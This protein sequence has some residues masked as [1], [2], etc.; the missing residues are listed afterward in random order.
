MSQPLLRGAPKLAGSLPCP[1]LEGGTH[2]LWVL[3]ARFGRDELQGKV[4]FRQEPFDPVELVTEDFR[5]GGT[6]EDLDESA[7]KNAPGEGQL[8]QNILDRDSITRS[9]LRA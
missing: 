3:K 7:L 2:V 6:A 1:L 4:G 9:S 8:G 5:L